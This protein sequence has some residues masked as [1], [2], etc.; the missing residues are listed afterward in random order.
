MSTP[1]LSSRS[2]AR[3]P[4]EI[5]LSIA[6]LLHLRDLNALLQ[7]CRHLASVFH[8]RFYRLAT[9]Y[10]FTEQYRLKSPLT[11]V[12][13][14]GRASGVRRLLE[15]GTDVN[16]LVDGF[17]ALHYATAGGH[18]DVVSL[19]IE[20]GA[21]HLEPGK[22]GKPP[23]VIAARHGHLDV[24]R[25]LVRLMGTESAG[26]QE[27]F[28]RAL[29]L[30]VYFGHLPVVRFMLENAGVKPKPSADEAGERTWFDLSR[31]NTLI[32]EA[33][34]SGNC[35][36]IQLLVDYGAT[37]P[38]LHRRSNHPLIVAAQNNHRQ[39]VEMLVKVGAESKSENSRG[40]VVDGRNEVAQF[41]LDS[42]ASTHAVGKKFSRLTAPQS[43][44]MVTVR[45]FQL[46]GENIDQTTADGRTP[47]QIALEE[48][49][50][51]DVI[52]TLLESGANPDRKGRGG[53]SAL[54]TLIVLKRHDLLETLLAAGASL[55]TADDKGNTP[56]LLAVSVSNT[57]AVELF[58]RCKADLSAKDNFG[59]SPLHVAA[60]HG[61]ANILGMLLDA[62]ADVTVTDNHGRIPLHYATM[63][64]NATAFKA[65]LFKHEKDETDY[66]I[67]SRSGRTVL[68]M[69][70]EG[71]H[72][73]I[74]EML[75][76]RGV[77]V[78]NEQEGYTS[79]HAAVANK[80]LEIAELLLSHGADPLLLDDYGRTPLDL[81]SADG[82]TLNRLLSSCDVTYIPTDE[83]TQT[84]KLKDSVVRFATGILNGQTGD[85]YKL[86]KCLVYLGN[87]D[88]ARSV[89]TQAAR[90]GI[91]EEDLR[92]SMAC[93]V[94]RKRLKDD[95]WSEVMVL[96][97]RNCH[98]L[99]LCNWGDGSP[100]LGFSSN[101]GFTVCTS[102]AH[103]PRA[104]ADWEDQL[105][106]LIATYS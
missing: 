1:K 94:C 74:V 25:L 87:G 66:L 76:E 97:C 80:H 89:F 13:E 9:T 31:D 20:A 16:K 95:G 68:E 6:E 18:G 38:P 49:S 8:D 92:Y 30:A 43:G 35:D 96:I 50:P 36:M 70:V 82:E 28:L 63:T 29:S 81:A 79:L 101:A 93:N 83:E 103:Y 52:H 61:S 78:G 3:L 69:A 58:L 32:H 91:N 100:F 24:I 10:T 106:L 98:D 46:Y 53:F 104:T 22:Q 67:P 42:G 102:S 17:S 88:A 54:H 4:T 27:L 105:R 41:L 14:H 59:R 65:I 77:E 39:A 99:D 5:L 44:N 45:L 56:L 73:A 23:I 90:S 85:Y 26:R 34:K 15:A 51:P 57:R 12:A 62:D 71:G 37:V 21:N 86:A 11:W 75:I 47:L 84:A 48:F 72:V 60:G 2:L 55:S 64:G 7:T 33:A 40:S 19:L